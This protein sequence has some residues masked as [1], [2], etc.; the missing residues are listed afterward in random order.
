MRKLI[1]YKIIK[2]L[3]YKI[4][5]D[6]FISH[7]YRVDNNLIVVD[8]NNDEFVLEYTYTGEK[9]IKKAYLN[10]MKDICRHSHCLIDAKKQHYEISKNDQLKYIKLVSIFWGLTNVAIYSILSF[11]FKSPFDPT[12]LTILGI[13]SAGNLVSFVTSNKSVNNEYDENVK[14]LNDIA[15]ELKSFNSAIKE[16]EKVDKLISNKNLKE[17]L[18]IKGPEKLS[19]STCVN[20][21]DIFNLSTGDLA[22]KV[23]V[24]KKCKEV[25]TTKRENYSDNIV[26]IESFQKRKELKENKS[27]N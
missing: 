2:K 18:S 23:E 15:A 13:T 4:E 19:L 21:G 26:P 14:K 22:L 25:L 8:G 20:S 11:V 1:N 27:R 12:L 6:S 9:E 24:L 5:S 3:G 17:S 10:Q 7:Y 16:L